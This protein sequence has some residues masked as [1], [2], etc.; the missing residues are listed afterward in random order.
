MKLSSVWAIDVTP[1]TTTFNSSELDKLNK[2][3]ETKKNKQKNLLLLETI[4][5]FFI[6]QSI[7]IKEEYNKI[8]EVWYVYIERKKKT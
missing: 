7:K 5:L 1:F 6:D 4:F 2:H 3:D 8:F